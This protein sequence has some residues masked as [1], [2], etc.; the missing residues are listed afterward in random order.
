MVAPSFSPASP[1]VLRGH[2][3]YLVPFDYERYVYR[4]GLAGGDHR[5]PAR[6][7]P[8]AG[9]AEDGRLIWRRIPAQISSPRATRAPYRASPLALSLASKATFLRLCD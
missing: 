6:S 3:S 5:Q 7:H 8:L 1:G 4:F 9:T 2:C